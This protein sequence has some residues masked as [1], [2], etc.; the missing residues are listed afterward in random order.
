MSWR[1]NFFFDSK[2]LELFSGVFDAVEILM[3][4]DFLRSNHG[5]SISSLISLLSTWISALLWFSYFRGFLCVTC[6]NFLMSLMIL[7]W[8][9]SFFNF[10]SPFSINL[11]SLLF[12][13]KPVIILILLNKLTRSL[14]PFSKGRSLPSV[15][16]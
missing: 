1:I 12:G 13:K 3:T 9:N 14:S 4:R 15:L 6:C 11:L 16:A 2:G 5:L 8:S 10:L 7:M